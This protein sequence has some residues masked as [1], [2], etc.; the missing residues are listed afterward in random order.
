MKCEL[1]AFISGSRPSSPAWPRDI[2]GA[3]FI[4]DWSHYY[5][6]IYVKVRKF[7]YYYFFLLRKRKFYYVAVL[8]SSRQYYYYFFILIIIEFR[9]RW[10]R[11]T[12]S[13]RLLNLNP[14]C[15]VKVAFLL[16][17]N[18]INTILDRVSV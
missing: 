2:S 18:T 6:T 17:G 5:G 4:V 16:I 9:N 10:I 14:Q 12:H 7:Y 15:C 11:S 3:R 8:S 1:D 13:C